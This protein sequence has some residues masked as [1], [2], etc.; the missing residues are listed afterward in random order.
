MTTVSVVIHNT[1]HR[2]IR[3]MLRS[4]AGEPI[5]RIFI[6]DNS[7]NDSLAPL[8]RDNPKTEY[9]HV[10]NRGF[11]AAHN[12]A[13]RRAAEMNSEYHLVLNPDVRWE[14]IIIPKLISEM[15]RF[16]S[17]DR[18][19]ALI[20]P[21]IF[22]PDGR[23]QHTC[24][25]LPTPLDVFGKRFL[26]HFL[27]KKRLKNYLLPAH[28]Y[29][30][31]FEVAYLQGSFMLFKTAALI[32]A[33]LFDERFFMYPEDIDI[34][35]RI[36]NKFAVFHTPAARIIHNHAAE[37]SEF[38]RMLL[39]HITNMIKYFNKWGWFFDHSR[40]QINKKIKKLLIND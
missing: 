39:I 2:L 8:F 32:D 21:L 23:L 31:E 40:R 22:Y 17:P 3:D 18:E 27:I 35:R 20:Q 12:I 9:R 5:D 38:N 25:L 11:G 15:R 24:R 33:G 34:S 19:C 7:P 10:E 30:K 14:G 16:S 6:I 28:L 37:S 13:I 4:L 26:P 1:A 36:F 29:Y